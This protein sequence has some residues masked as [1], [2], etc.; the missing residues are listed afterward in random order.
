M[1]T[2]GD[3]NKQV[4]ARQYRVLAGKS[5]DERVRMT[6]ELC[7]NVRQLLVA[8]ISRRHP[9]WGTEQIQREVFARTLEPKL[10]QQ[11]LSQGVI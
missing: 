3:T 11:M 7:E 2:P 4:M 8:G 9:E 5:V 6:F 1:Q 10:Y